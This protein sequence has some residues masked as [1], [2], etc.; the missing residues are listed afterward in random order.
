MVRRA[1]DRERRAAAG[2][3]RAKDTASV[4][5]SSEKAGQ[6]TAVSGAG[7]GSADGAALGTSRGE[8]RDCT[9]RTILRGEGLVFSGTDRSELGM[10]SLPSAGSGFGGIAQA[11]Q[12]GMLPS[13]GS[14][15]GLGSLSS[16]TG[17]GSMSSLPSGIAPPPVDTSTH[18]GDVPATIQTV[19]PTSF[20]PANGSQNS[21]T[22]ESIK[23]RLAALKQK[24]KEIK[25]EEQRTK[26]ALAP[27]GAIGKPDASQRKS[28]KQASRQTKK[29]ASGEKRVPVG[30]WTKEEDALLK[31][32]VEEHGEGQWE[33][34][35]KA[36][37]TGRTSK[38]VHT[39]WLRAKGRIIDL[40]R[41]CNQLNHE[42]TSMDAERQAKIMDESGYLLPV[43]SG[44]L[45]AAFGA[46]SVPQ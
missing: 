21:Q 36:M 22:S 34:K 17:L 35:A 1:E 5:L 23:E 25:A 14:L 8:G 46:N 19:Q 39:R 6:S 30:P 9:T 32:L 31:K 26:S 13:I 37:G 7:D 24:R 12:S 33:A 45:A 3:L 11:L 40:P 28:A 15:T 27:K 18:S 4:R 44:S 43:L 38:A 2:P 29:A 42:M 20:A 16:L 41:G 10:S